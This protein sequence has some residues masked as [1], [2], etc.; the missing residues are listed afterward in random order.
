MVTQLASQVPLVELAFV[1]KCVMPNILLLN[2]KWW[3]AKLA[4]KLL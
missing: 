4:V 3:E 2:Q 1:Q